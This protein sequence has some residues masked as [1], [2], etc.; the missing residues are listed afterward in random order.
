MVFHIPNDLI[1]KLSPTGMHAEA[2]QWRVQ[3]SR[4][5]L[6]FKKRVE[7]DGGQNLVESD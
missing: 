6:T 2:V 1:D 3:R 5:K 7:N 4:A